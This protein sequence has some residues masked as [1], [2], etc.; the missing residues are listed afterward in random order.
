MFPLLGSLPCSARNVNGLASLQI[1]DLLKRVPDGESGYTEDAVE[2]R[3]RQARGLDDFVIAVDV[4]QV[5]WVRDVRVLTPLGRRENDRSDRV[6]GILGVQDLGE[7]IADDGALGGIVGE[8]EADN[9]RFQLRG[10]IKKRKDIC[11]GKT[12]ETRLF[13]SK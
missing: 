10:D 9:Y 4:T 6:L 5:L 1:A 13:G 3:V 12:V 2:E 7:D 8:V 11:V